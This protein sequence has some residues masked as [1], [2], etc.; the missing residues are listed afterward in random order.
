MILHAVEAGA[1]RGAGPPV[2][3]LH[4]LFGAAGNFAAIQR[5]LGATRR[6]V[7]F[8]LRNHGASPHDPVMSYAEMAADVLDSL[9][10][11]GVPQ[12]ALIGHSMGGKVAM[13]AA[14]LRPDRVGRLL[15]ADIA[16]VRYDPAYRGIADAML[17][18]PLHPGL[19]RAAADA[20]LAPAVPDPAVRGFLLQNLRL[21]PAPGWRIGLREIA[22]G[23]P[24]IEGWDAPPGTQYAGPVLMLRGER[25]EYVR[26]EHRPAVRALFP[27][28]RFMTLKGA[29]HWLH[30]DAPDV[31]V[32]VAQAFLDG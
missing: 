16:P 11:L 18:L 27:M 20:A 17:A 29:G 24:D 6:V 8:D 30:A 22:A 19:T 13:R 1:D 28:A 23:L 7:A 25:S 4:G 2:V 15:V 5:R 10:A 26:P 32:E 3:M 21:G 9:A 31:F 14:L 12:A